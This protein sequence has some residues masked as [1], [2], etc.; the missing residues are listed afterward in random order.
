MSLST[1]HSCS[2]ETNCEWFLSDIVDNPYYD[3]TWW[4]INYWFIH[5]LWFTS[6][7][8]L[9]WYWSC[10]KLRVNILLSSVDCW[11][12]WYIS[13]NRILDYASTH[14]VLLRILADDMKWNEMRM[15]P[16]WFRWCYPYYWL[17]WSNLIDAGFSNT[18]LLN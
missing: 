18:N 1:I 16:F 10:C 3:S 2:D 12:I 6:D 9:D 13:L 15:F 5:S 11:T 4:Q 14:V 7:L 17:S 8:L